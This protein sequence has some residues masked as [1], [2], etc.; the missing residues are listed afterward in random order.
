MD[1][2][3]RWPL[4]LACEIIISTA[5]PPLRRQPA[6]PYVQARRVHQLWRW[7]RPEFV[8]LELQQ[9]LEL[10]QSFPHPVIPTQ[11]VRLLNGYLNMYVQELHELLL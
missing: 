1:E 5:P 2:Q 4:P 9:L 3:S 10:V 6:S 11:T 7:Q 8:A